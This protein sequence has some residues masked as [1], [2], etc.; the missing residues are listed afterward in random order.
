MSDAMD[1]Y[2]RQAL[3]NWAAEQQPPANGR[4][5]LLLLAASPSAQKAYFEHQQ[6]ASLDL[7][8]PFSRHVNPA[9]DFYDLPYLLAVQLTYTT[10]RRVT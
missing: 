5:R 9:S 3:K 2:I 8:K 4:A 6:A 7:T 1:G 10:L